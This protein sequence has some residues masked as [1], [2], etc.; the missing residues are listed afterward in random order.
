[1]KS[2]IAIFS[3]CV[4]VAVSACSQK[5]DE[6]K[7]PKKIK[8]SF[9]KDFPGASASW[10][11]EDGKYEANFKIGNE[12]KSAN[13]NLDGTM[14]ENEVEIQT[15]ELPAYVQTYISDHYKDKKIK[16]AAK[17]TNADGSINYEAEVDGKALLFDAEGHFL[18]IA[19]E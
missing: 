6:E 3:V 8:T 13:Y 12:E 19:E 4:I 10:V 15:T 14:A 2:L 17:I 7:V 16:S 9:A 5:V 1:M 11:K 18:K